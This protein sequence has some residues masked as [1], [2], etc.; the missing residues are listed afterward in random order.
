MKEPDSFVD[1]LVDIIVNNVTF[2]PLP[3]KVNRMMLVMATNNYAPT[4][5]LIV[6]N[7]HITYLD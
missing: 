4:Q 1:Q 7:N 6:T 3:L 2:D 5:Y